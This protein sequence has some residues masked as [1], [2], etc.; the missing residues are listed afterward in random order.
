MGRVVD[1]E[2]LWRS[3]SPVSG[4]AYY[5]AYSEIRDALASGASDGRT[6]RRILENEYGRWRLFSIDRLRQ[7]GHRC[8]TF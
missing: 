7:F 5:R 4:D 1:A 6:I 3:L 2:R 8:D